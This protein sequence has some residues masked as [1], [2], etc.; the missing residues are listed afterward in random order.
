LLV[1]IGA[2][3]P[4]FLIAMWLKLH[5]EDPNEWPTF[6]YYAFHLAITMVAM[7]LTSIV[8][9]VSLMRLK[10]AKRGEEGKKAT[11]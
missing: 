5:N 6:N 4:A 8:W 7:V 11:K 3:I 10:E 9:T 1:A 2:F